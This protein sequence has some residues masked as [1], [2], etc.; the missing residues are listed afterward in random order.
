MKKLIIGM[1][2]MLVALVFSG[3]SG[4]VSNMQVANPGEKITLPKEGRAQ[5]VFLRPSSFGFAIQ[6][7]VFEIKN[8]TPEI[9]GIVAAKKKMSYD[10]MPGKHTFMVVGESADFMYADVEANKTYY[11]MVTPRMGLWKARFSLA[12]VSSIEYNSPEFTKSLEE[13]ELVMPNHSTKTW[14]QNNFD[15]IQS[16]YAEYYQKWMEKDVNSRPLLSISDGI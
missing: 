15:S 6:S 12:P 10:V 5:I 8:N 2:A 11:A 7:S 1:L 9:V 3:C 14:A 16:K 13:C 4:S